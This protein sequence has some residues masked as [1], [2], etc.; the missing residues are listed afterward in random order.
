MAVQRLDPQT[1][2]LA[3]NPDFLHVSP[4]ALMDDT[5][6]THAEAGYEKAPESN[7]GASSGLLRLG[8]NQRP[9]D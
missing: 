4:V 2:I 6:L 1:H 3:Y 5:V 9:S 7:S 8:L